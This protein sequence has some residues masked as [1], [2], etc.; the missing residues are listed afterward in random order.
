MNDSEYDVI[1]IGAGISGL[2]AAYSLKKRDP[3]SKILV[4]EG[5]E[6]V[7]GRTQTVQ[8][9]SS[10]GTDY[11]DL[12]GQ[13]VGR[14]QR[15]IIKLLNELGLE[16]YPQYITGKKCQQLGET[17]IRTYNSNIPKLS[18]LALLDLHWSITK[19]DRYA[20]QLSIE[21]PFSH[22]CAQ[23]WDAIT[24]SDYL[25][26]NLYTQAAVEANAAALH[27]VL[28]C[29]T[30][31]VSFLYYL[32]YIS[33][34]DGVKNLV[35]ATEN[36]A[37]EWKIKGGAQQISEILA[38]RIG[39]D[40]VVLSSPVTA[41]Q[42]TETSVTVTTDKGW[43]AKASYVILAMPPKAIERIQI[44][45]RLAADRVDFMKR[46]PMGNM[47]KVIIT[48]DKAFW[49]SENFSGEIVTDGGETSVP[50]CSRG[51]L[52]ITYDATSHNGCPALVA[53]MAGEQAVEWTIQSA[54]VRQKGVL[55]HFAAFFGSEVYN[56][57][58]YIE[59]DWNLEPFSFGAPVSYLAPGGM[60]NFAK[61]IRRPEGRLHFAGTE[62]ATS[63]SGYMNGAVQAGE[64]AALEVLLRL[65]PSALTEVDMKELKDPRKVATG[66]LGNKVLSLK[67]SRQK[68]EY[69]SLAII[70]SLG[71][72]L[73][74][75]TGTVFLVDRLISNGKVL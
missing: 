14:S 69:G 43:N 17:R 8:L 47:V 37:Q 49:R 6:R 58:D 29:E 53:F 71:I 56:F 9:V 18:W 75:V 54:I 21:D 55:D 70:V 3:A 40:A 25:N 67:R 44:T 23:E 31:Q 27:S 22:P 38:D 68:K 61:S 64:R 24:V 59:K 10:S 45:P 63:F 4:L 65:Q 1:V 26:K 74:L 51:P 62:T 33:M 39:R 35:E 52:C 48:Y 32:L 11:W 13:W 73:G 57:L 15:D 19:L 7:G 12:G 66:N 72:G 16:T 42:Q 5:K 30:N 60:E 2:N 20:R 41:I 36:A 28:G 50:E 46:M 34:A